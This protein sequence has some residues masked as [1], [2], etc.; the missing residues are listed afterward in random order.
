MAPCRRVLLFVLVFF[1]LL[2]V[3]HSMFFFPKLPR[4]IFPSGYRGFHLT[5]NKKGLDGLKWFK[6]VCWKN[7]GTHK[8][9]GSNTTTTNHFAKSKDCHLRKLK[10]LVFTISSF[11]HNSRSLDSK[12]HHEGP[13]LDHRHRKA[14]TLGS[15][16]ENITHVSTSERTLGNLNKRR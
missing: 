2:F 14:Y 8:V 16:Q 10:W 15:N 12:S 1:F 6:G 5:I 11:V 7:I 3:M 13:N 9:H 4:V